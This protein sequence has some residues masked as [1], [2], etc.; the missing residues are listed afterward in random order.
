MLDPK[1]IRTDK[2]Y[3]IKNLARRGVK[4]NLDEI[5][6]LDS[7]RRQ[8]QSRLDKLRSEKNRV[9]KE[10]GL[11]KSETKDVSESKSRMRELNQELKDT[12]KEFNKLSVKLNV[13]YMDL[14]N[15]LHD[16]VPDGDQESMNQEIRVRGEPTFFDF[17]VKDHVELGQDLGLFDF[18]TAAK[19]S[20]SRFAVFKNDFARLH[21]ALIQFMIDVHT[22]ENHYTEYYVP[23][24]VK[25]SSLEGT[26]NLPKFKDD[27][28]KIDSENDFYLIPTAEVPLTNL[29]RDK[30]I[31]SK[32][33]PK[34]FVA[35]TPCYR[36]EA[37]SYGKDTRGMIRQH[38]FEKV[39]LVHIVKPEESYDSLEELTRNAE[40]ILMKLGLPYRV[41]LLCSG[42]SSFAA[43]K[44]YDIEVWLPSQGRYR[45][46]SSCSNCESF[47]ARRMKARWKNEQTGQNEFVHTLNG[48]GLAVG[49]TLIAILENYQQKDGTIT[50]P[51]VIRSYMG[52]QKVIG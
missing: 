9:S 31:N 46:I 3:V 25:S 33:L 1:R 47:Q 38:Q 51:E 27:L 30:I 13:F 19:I 16:S 21:R 24:L 50:V 22:Q 20:G 36:S 48:S 4:V 8:L 12:E 41:V 14:P 37:G 15:L 6:H 49:R 11:A 35:H 7:Q 26:G 52:N 44:T 32:D 5:I 2:N 45:E 23:S 18:K 40:S 17:K 34:K 10:I 39:E 29:V 42:D 43:S 28:F